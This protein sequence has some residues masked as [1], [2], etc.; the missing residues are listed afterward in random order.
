MSNQFMFTSSLNRPDPDGGY[1]FKNHTDTQL[2]FENDKCSHRPQQPHRK[3]RTT[4]AHKECPINSV[5][6]N[7][8]KLESNIVRGMLIL[9]LFLFLLSSPSFSFS[10]CLSVG[11]GVGVLLSLLRASLFEHLSISQARN[12]PTLH[13]TPVRGPCSHAHTILVTAASASSPWNRALSF[14][15]RLQQEMDMCEVPPHRGAPFASRQT[16]RK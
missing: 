15:W 2:H 1:H 4:Q 16:V 9:S 5:V 13:T 3:E 12:Q 7:K 8:G 6:G 14:G 11:Q 10:L